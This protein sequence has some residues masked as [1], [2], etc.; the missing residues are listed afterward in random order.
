MMYFVRGRFDSKIPFFR[1]GKH[2]MP[3]IGIRYNIEK[4]KSDI[5]RRFKIKTDN[6]RY[7]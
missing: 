6:I 5:A 1:V 7:A 4:T 3:T 2:Y